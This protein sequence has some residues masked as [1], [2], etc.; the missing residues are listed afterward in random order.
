LQRQA[1]MRSRLNGFRISCVSLLTWLRPGVNE[2]STTTFATE[3]AVA[4]Q[5]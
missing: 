3:Y 5:S 2:R 4:L 1:E